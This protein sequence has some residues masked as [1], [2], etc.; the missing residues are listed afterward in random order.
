MVFV[1]REMASFMLETDR[2]EV[3]LFVP[4][5]TD[6]IREVCRSRLLFLEERHLEPLLGNSLEKVDG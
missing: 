1:V 6:V 5:W 2:V 3:F 4:S